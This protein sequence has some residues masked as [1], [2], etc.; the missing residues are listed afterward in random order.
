MSANNY[1]LVQVATSLYVIRVFAPC[2]VRVNFVVDSDAGTYSTDDDTS[3]EVGLV[4][5]GLSKVDFLGEITV[6]VR[7]SPPDDPSLRAAKLVDSLSS[8]W[9]AQHTGTHPHMTQCLPSP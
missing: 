6:T 5:P 7:A 4:A 9:P 2:A 3:L 1:S 8:M